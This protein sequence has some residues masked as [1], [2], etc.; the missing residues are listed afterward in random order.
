MA[1]LLFLPGAGA[2]ADFWQPAAVG[3]LPGRERHFFAWPGLGDE[4]PRNGVSSL[5]DV[6]AMVLEEMQGPVDLIAQSMGGLI[7]IKVALA[8]PGLVRRLVLAGTSAGL[9]VEALGGGEWRETYR[10]QFPNAAPWITQIREDLSSRLHLITAPTLLLWGDRD[11]VSPLPV[12]NRL[13]EVLPN[14]SLRIIAGGA[15]D[16]AITHASE[17][18]PLIAGHLE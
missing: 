12:G 18:T 1:K 15:H 7:A 17:V 14:A 4:P 2:R 10:L 3:L 13:L 8:E 11:V 5:D 9:P 16:F 6:V